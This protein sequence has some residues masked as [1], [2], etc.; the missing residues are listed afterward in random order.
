M[1][2]SYDGA[3]RA[4]ARRYLLSNRQAEVLGL[5]ARG[6]NAAYV[7]EKLCI[8]RSTAKSHMNKIYRKLDIHTQQELLMMM[9]DELAALEAGTEPSAAQLR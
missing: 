1:A 7:Q 2:A 4:I 9:E 6:H 3:C 5:L 8:T